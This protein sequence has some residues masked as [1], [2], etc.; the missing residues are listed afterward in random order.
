MATGEPMVWEWR[1][2]ATISAWSV[3][4][5]HS[6]APTVALLPPPQLAVDRLHRNGYTCRES[7][8]CRHEALSVGLPCGLKTQHSTR[9]FILADSNIWL[10]SSVSTTGRGTGN[11]QLPAVV[12]FGREG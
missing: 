4:I 12:H 6:P 5:F 8:E 11:G 7:G 9:I 1:T 2:P 3:S 10:P